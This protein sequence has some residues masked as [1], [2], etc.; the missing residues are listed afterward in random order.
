MRKQLTK[1]TI[2]DGFEVVRKRSKAASVQ[3]S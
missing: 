1:S 2:K 3:T